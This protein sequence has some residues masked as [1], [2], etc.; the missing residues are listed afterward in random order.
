MNVC[1]HHDD[2]AFVLYGFYNIIIIIY[3]IIFMLIIITI[4]IMLIIVLIIMLMINFIIIMLVCDGVVDSLGSAEHS[5]VH[6]GV[7]RSG[8]RDAEVLVQRID[9]SRARRRCLSDLLTALHRSRWSCHQHCQHQH[10][11][12]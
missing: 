5:A 1:C 3:F 8:V 10:D 9:G 12:H 11:G 2:H 7:L 6:S 4:I